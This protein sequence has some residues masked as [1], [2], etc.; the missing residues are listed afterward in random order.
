MI[1][2]LYLLICKFEMDISIQEQYIPVVVNQLHGLNMGPRNAKTEFN[3]KRVM[4][5][6]KDQ[7]RLFN[8]IQDILKMEC[9]K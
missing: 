9:I 8:V 5:L 7:K 4:E 1:Q 3:S 6:G 2:L